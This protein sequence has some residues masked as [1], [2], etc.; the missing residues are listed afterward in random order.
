MPQGSAFPSPTERVPDSKPNQSYNYE[1]IRRDSKA[2]GKKKWTLNC[3]ANLNET[4]NA[5]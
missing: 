5:S 2:F 3:K 1:L 4:V